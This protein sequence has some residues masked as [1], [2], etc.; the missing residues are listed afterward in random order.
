MYVSV[1]ISESG[2][3]RPDMKK[4][5]G[6]RLYMLQMLKAHVASVSYGLLQQ[7][8]KPYAGR[9]L[10]CFSL[11]KTHLRLVGLLIL[12]NIYLFESF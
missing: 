1:R 9:I 7:T 2:I 11:I 6:V 12:K 10:V 8:N 3:D 4:L 5:N